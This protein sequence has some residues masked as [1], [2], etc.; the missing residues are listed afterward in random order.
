[1]KDIKLGSSY[2]LNRLTRINL[3]QNSIMLRFFLIDFK[4]LN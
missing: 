1:M 2:E 3:K 4:K